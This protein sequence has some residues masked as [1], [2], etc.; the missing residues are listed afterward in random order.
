VSYAHSLQIHGPECGVFG[1]NRHRGKCGSR[2]YQCGWD[3]R[4][5]RERFPIARPRSRG[6]PTLHCD[7]GPKQRN[8]AADQGITRCNRILTRKSICIPTLAGSAHAHMNRATQLVEKLPLDRETLRC[9]TSAAGPRASHGVRAQLKPV[10]S[11]VLRGCRRASLS[12]QWQAPLR[13]SVL[14]RLTR[15]CR[16]SSSLCDE[17]PRTGVQSTALAASNRRSL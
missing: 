5:R 2:Q 16:A 7:G 1:R 11:S 17:R 14:L 3:R 9:A 4:Q 8:T 6:A 13:R 12:R 10:A 15:S